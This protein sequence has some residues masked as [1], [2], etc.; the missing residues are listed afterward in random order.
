MEDAEKEKFELAMLDRK[1]V[2]GR[3]LYHRDACLWIQE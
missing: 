2:P 1:E 3:H